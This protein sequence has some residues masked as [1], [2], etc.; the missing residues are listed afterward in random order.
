M[1]TARAIDDEGSSIV[2]LEFPDQTRSFDEARNAV[3]FIGKD[4]MF[5]VPFF[6]ET[7]A[8]NAPSAGEASL[9]VAFDAARAVIYDVAREIYGNTR[10]NMYVLTAA[11]FR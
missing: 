11:D 7:S 9:L 5:E 2:T 4:G 1:R 3:R 10:R 6:V 8:L